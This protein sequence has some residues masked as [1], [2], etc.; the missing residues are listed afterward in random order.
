M[1]PLKIQLHGFSD[2]SKRAYGAVVYIR[3]VYEDGHIDVRLIS[4][5]TKVAPI[6]QQSIPRLELL[7][8]TILVR[9]VNTVKHRNRVLD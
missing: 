7:G 6:K 8:A 9:L 2:A 3:S 4:S 5:K 1:Q